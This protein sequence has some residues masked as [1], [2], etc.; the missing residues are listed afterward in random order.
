LEGRESYFFVYYIMDNPAHIISKPL[1][2][3]V[4]LVREDSYKIQINDCQ[5]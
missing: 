5:I 2:T 3:F 1:R 4:T